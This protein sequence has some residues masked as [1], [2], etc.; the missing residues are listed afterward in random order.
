VDEPQ[1]W[2]AQAIA[3]RVAA[4]RFLGGVGNAEC[5]AIAKYQQTVEKAVKAIVSE[6]RVRGILS[7]EIGRRHDVERFVG[8]LIRLPHAAENRSVST[9]LR[10]MLDA[11][12]RA[13]IRAVDALA[14][15]WPAPG[16]A[17]GRNTEYPFQDAGGVWRYPAAP[18]VFSAAEIAQ[19]RDLA[20]RIVEGAG[21]VI[22]A[23]RRGPR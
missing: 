1:A 22:A 15:R 20:H 21:R 7:V 18:G 5:H 6:L 3:D 9:R 8:P 19:F 10:S 2:I 14:P 4:E 17:P 16:Q 13:A 11:N 12:T 23:V